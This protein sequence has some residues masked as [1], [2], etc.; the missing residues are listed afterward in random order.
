MKKPV[1]AGSSIL[2]AGLFALT[3]LFLLAIPAQAA[4][5]QPVGQATADDVVKALTKNFN[6]KD[7]NACLDLMTD[8]AM[9]MVVN[10]SDL[11]T[12]TL[13]KDTLTYKGKQGPQSQIANFF[14]INFTNGFTI[15]STNFKS[16]PTSFNGPMQL[17]I[18]DFVVETDVQGTLE[19]GKIKT[20]V[21][22]DKSISQNAGQA[23][24][25][26]SKSPA[27]GAG[28]ESLS[29]AQRPAPLPGWSLAFAASGILSLIGLRL[30]RK[31]KN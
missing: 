12:G 9:V 23:A 5:A 16:T 28:T 24:P 27:T 8:D 6:A 18:R 22:T 19:G 25:I 4:L 11:A 20:L 2:L 15:R 31:R 21:I 3:Y 26:P 29:Q 14:T 1:Q 30:S 13:S 7:L 10:P 17:A